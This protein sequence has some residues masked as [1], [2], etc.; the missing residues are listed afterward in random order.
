MTIPA[1]CKSDTGF[2]FPGR[3]NTYC[4]AGVKKGLLVFDCEF[5]HLIPTRRKNAISMLSALSNTFA[6][7]GRF[8]S[9]DFD[10]R[11]FNARPLEQLLKEPRRIEILDQQ[12]IAHFQSDVA[13]Y[14][15]LYTPPFCQEEWA[16]PPKTFATGSN[17]GAALE[18][19]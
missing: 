17:S 16:N 15:W 4:S 5:V 3:L 11:R 14:R 9:W 1:L 18:R 2:Q 10:R 7:F 12:K 8:G 13:Y 19:K 6:A